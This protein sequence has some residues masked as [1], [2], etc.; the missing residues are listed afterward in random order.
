MFGFS[1]INCNNIKG[2]KP[3]RDREI[4]KVVEISGNI[5]NDT[6]KMNFPQISQ[7]S[8]LHIRRLVENSVSRTIT[9]HSE[10][11]A[12]SFIVHYG[13]I[14]KFNRSDIAST[15]LDFGIERSFN[16][17]Q[18]RTNLIKF[19]KRLAPAIIPVPFPLFL[20]VRIPFH[21][22]EQGSD[23]AFFLRDLV[24][25][26]IA[27]SLDIHPHELAGHNFTPESFLRQ[28]RF[29]IGL[30]R[31]IYEPETGNRLVKKVLFP[32]LE[33]LEKIDYKGDIIFCPASGDNEIFEHEYNNLTQLCSELKK[34]KGIKQN[35]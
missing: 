33:Y 7:A 10:Q 22:D 12:K 2:F 1:F 30:I 15:T 3:E 11:L 32:W 4:F 26:N 6:A 18:L 27:L 9:E 19:I 21:T 8:R 5:I 25:N 16:N 24:V 23:Y 31:F 34:H 29:D 35:G 13:D 14:I 28:L 17:P 20:P